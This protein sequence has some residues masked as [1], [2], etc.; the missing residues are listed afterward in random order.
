MSPPSGRTSP[1]PSVAVIGLGF[2]RAHVPAF[3][4]AGARVVAVTTLRMARPTLVSARAIAIAAA[5]F[6]AVGLLKLNT[7]TV[8][9]VMAALGLWLNRPEPAP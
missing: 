4:A 1:A 7:P 3:Q 8:I 6:A 2:G 5:T 9:V